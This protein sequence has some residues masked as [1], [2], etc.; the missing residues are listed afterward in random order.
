M[1]INNNEKEITTELPDS[2]RALLSSP[3][4]ESV[5]QGIILIQSLN[6]KDLI[7]LLSNGI[8]F[9][10]Q[11]G[12]VIDRLWSA[13]T[14][15]KIA[16]RTNAALL[17]LGMFREN[18]INN[19]QEFNFSRE[20]NLRDISF[21]ENAK[22]AK[23]IRLDYTDVTDFKALENVEC[24]E[25]LSLIE[26]NNLSKLPNFR[27]ENKILYLS[28]SSEALNS[29]CELE[30]LVNLETLIINNPGKIGSID[31][32]KHC[33]KLKKL[34][35]SSC[36]SITDLNIISSL[37]E[38]EELSL[39]DLPDNFNL[40]FIKG[41]KNLELIRISNS[42]YYDASPISECKGLK[43]ISF[44]DSSNVSNIWLLIENNEIEELILPNTISTSN[45]KRYSGDEFIN[46]KAKLEKLSK[47]R[48]KIKNAY[49]KKDYRDF[50]SCLSF[51]NCLETGIKWEDAHNCIEEINRNNNNVLNKIFFENISFVNFRFYISQKSPFAFIYEEYKDIS[52]LGNAFLYLA[53]KSDLFC[54]LSIEYLDLSNI[55]ITDLSLLTDM[56]SLIN[57][58]LRRMDNY[59]PIQKNKINNKL[60]IN[61]VEQEKSIGIYNID[62]FIN[63][64][65]NS[66][67]TTR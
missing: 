8:H 33:A 58:K 13:T 66:N 39:F 63:L 42:E 27:K 51:V 15:I 20:E 52:W 56:Q 5:K 35:L 45:F 30:N 49:F 57:L 31:G 14:G 40:D 62:E 26:C 50:F 25:K 4:W 11:N 16:N 23:T 64:I 65:Q 38:I 47:N 60:N 7:E 10:Q 1:S 21:L 59:F 53:K 37:T 28:I 55:D 19:V 9:S 6:N 61:L 54:P 17:I 41:F 22:S 43:Y 2:L 34:S 46:L 48:L 32:I 12:L 24:L 18:E 3:E 44:E 36:N 29:L 67:A